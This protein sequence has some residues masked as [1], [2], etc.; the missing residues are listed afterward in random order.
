MKSKITLL[1]VLMLGLIVLSVGTGFAEDKGTVFYL[2]P[3]QFDEMQTTAAKEIKNVVEEAGYECKVLVAGNEDVSLQINQMENA[4]TQDPVAIILAATNSTAIADSV[5]RARDEGIPIIIYDRTI[6]DTYVDFT[7]VAG[8][9]KMGIIAGNQIAELLK[10]RYGEVKGNVFD[11][12]GDPGDMYTVK[13]EEGFKEVM[14]QYPNVNITTKVTHGWEATTGA[15]TTEDWIVA[16]PDTDLIFAHADHMASAIAARLETRGY[17]PGE[18]MLVSTAGMPMGLDLVREG[19][20]QVTVQQP[21][22]AQAKGVAMFLDKIVNRECPKPGTY[23]VGG[24]T[25]ELVYQDYGPELQ[26][27]GAAITKENVENPQWWGNKAA[28]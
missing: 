20:A 27:P 5:E 19:W 3:N 1:F 21:V 18:I 28:K 4:I 9:K 24:L 25:A 7:S 8:C 16:N 14:E 10:E 17:D 23:D 13:I 12:M 15:N 22:I 11:L 26:I 2:A 6:T